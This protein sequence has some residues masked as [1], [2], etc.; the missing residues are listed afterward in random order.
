MN[1]DSRFNVLNSIDGRLSNYTGFR[2][3]S[4]LASTI[5]CKIWQNMTLN[6]INIEI[7]KLLRPKNRGVTFES[8]KFNL[9]VIVRPTTVW[10]PFWIC[11]RDKK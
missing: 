6:F 2:A 11:V 9:K 7:M 4:R 10:Q 8:I 3:D 5:L 1:L